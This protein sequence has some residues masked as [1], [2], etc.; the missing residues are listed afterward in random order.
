MGRL[1][2]HSQPVE[3]IEN[4]CSQGRNVFLYPLISQNY[5]D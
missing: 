3:N 4:T 2:N 1:E 5:T